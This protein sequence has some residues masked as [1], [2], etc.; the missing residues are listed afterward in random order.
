MRKTYLKWKCRRLY[1]KIYGYDMHNCGN[2][3]QKL[4]DSRYYN[5]LVSFNKTADSLA[6]IDPDCPTFRYELNK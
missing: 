5:L 2:S 3:M 1:L 6:K 4:V